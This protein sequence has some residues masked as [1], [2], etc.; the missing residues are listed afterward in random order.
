MSDIKLLNVEELKNEIMKYMYE[1]VTDSLV[2]DITRIR[3][4]DIIHEHRSYLVIDDLDPITD[5]HNLIFISLL[6]GMKQVRLFNDNE[7]SFVLH[8]VEEFTKYLGGK[9]K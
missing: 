5:K 1:I 9:R 2:I 3:G 4:N 6:S 8:H 7:L